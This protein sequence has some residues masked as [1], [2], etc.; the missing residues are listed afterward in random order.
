MG[1]K[2][3]TI[4]IMLDLETVG[5]CDNP[6]ITQLSAVAFSFEDGNILG[7]FNEHIGIRNS[8]KKG[9]KIDSSTIEW[10]LSQSDDI[11]NEVFMKALLSETKIEDILVAF[12]EWLRKLKLEFGLDHKTNINTWGNGIAADNKWIQQAYKLCNMEVPWKYYE[13]R[14]VRTLVDIGKRI[15]N[16]DHK[17]LVF[18][19]KVHNALDDCKHQIKYCLEVYN[20]IKNYSI[21]KSSSS[22]SSSS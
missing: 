11:Y 22:S 16:H 20:L 4:D 3:A 21:N 7:T 8:V 1:S 13:D 10:W 14:D 15:F 9:F 12:T 19:G 18:E 5:L 2:Y 17:K 6:V